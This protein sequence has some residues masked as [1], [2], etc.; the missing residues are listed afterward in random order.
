MTNITTR[1]TAAICA[2]AISLISIQTIVTV[3]ADTLMAGPA[4]TAFAPE[5]A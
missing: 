1:F 5:I 3:P 4:T 2:I